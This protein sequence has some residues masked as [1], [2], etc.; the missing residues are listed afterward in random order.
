ML[1]GHSELRVTMNFYAHLQKQTASKAAR[2][3]DAERRQARELRL[4]LNDQ[5]FRLLGFSA[6]ST[7]Q[8]TGRHEDRGLNP[9]G[10]AAGQELQPFVLGRRVIRLMQFDLDA[11]AP[12]LVVG[13]TEARS[14]EV[15]PTF[16][17]FVATLVVPG[18]VRVRRS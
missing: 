13:I 7:C 9:T 12:S 3:M 17:R 6:L 15:Q 1:L 5:H 18:V 14:D 4:A 10:E 2:H 11:D 8:P 16:R